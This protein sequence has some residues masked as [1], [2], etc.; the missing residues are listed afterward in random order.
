MDVKLLIKPVKGDIKYLGEIVR[1]QGGDIEIVKDDMKTVKAEVKILRGDRKFLQGEIR[2]LGDKMD[3]KFN[4]A[5]D[6]IT[7]LAKMVKDMT[8][9]FSIHNLTHQRDSEKLED[10][11]NRVSRLETAIFH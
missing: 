3:K 11:E 5:M 9:E 2:A 1:V 8:E 7:G 4:T 6:Q 10:H